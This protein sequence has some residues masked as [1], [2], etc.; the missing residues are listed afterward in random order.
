MPFVSISLGLSALADAGT[1]LLIIRLARR[2]ERPQVGIATALLWSIAPMSVTFAIGGM[3][4]SFYIL[5]IITIFFTCIFIFTSWPDAVCA[6]RQADRH[7]PPSRKLGVRTG[8]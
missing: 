2:W 1:C 7:N 8:N 6:G 4:T 3:E 5:C